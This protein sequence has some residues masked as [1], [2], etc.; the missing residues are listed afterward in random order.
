[1]KIWAFC[2]APEQYQ[3]LSTHGGDEDWIIYTP[4]NGPVPSHLWSAFY[5]DETYVMG[6]GHVDRHVLEDGSI[7]VIFAHA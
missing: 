6:L 1:M 5:S 7:V 3:A 4:K 2:D